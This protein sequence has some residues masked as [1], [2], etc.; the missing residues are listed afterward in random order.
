MALFLID[1]VEGVAA[2]RQRDAS[3]GTAARGKTNMRSCREVAGYWF[4]GEEE[5][6]SSIPQKWAGRVRL[7]GTRTA[8]SYTTRDVC[9]AC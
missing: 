5:T 8:A 4:T 1:D 7:C 2:T 9:K 3:K 6:S